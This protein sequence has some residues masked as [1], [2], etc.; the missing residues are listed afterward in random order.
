MFVKCL[1]I[2]LTE[3]GL[4]YNIEAGIEPPISGGTTPIKVG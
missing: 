4:G 2:D 1:L 3:T